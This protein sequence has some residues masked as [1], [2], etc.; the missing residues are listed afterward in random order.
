VT[1][2][3]TPDNRVTMTVEI[4]KDSVG[5]QVNLGNGFTVPSIDTKNVITQ[6]TVNNGD[7]AVI[8]AFTRRRS[9]TMSPRCHSSAICRSW[10]TCSK[11]R[12]RR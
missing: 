7:T 12:G 10:D 2:Q 5:Q 4:R 6:I 1:P 9:T 8:A 11:R 3:I